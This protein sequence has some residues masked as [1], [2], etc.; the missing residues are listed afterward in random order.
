MAQLVSVCL[1]SM[2]ESARRVLCVHCAPQR[3]DIAFS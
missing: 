2:E 1:S 3:E